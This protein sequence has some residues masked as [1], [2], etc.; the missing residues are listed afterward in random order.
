MFLFG[1]KSFVI[2]STRAFL[3]VALIVVKLS[4]FLSTKVALTD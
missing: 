4:V 3:T 2:D 1:V